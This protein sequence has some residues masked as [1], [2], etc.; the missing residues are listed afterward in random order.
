MFIYS[1]YWVN[2]YSW[3]FKNY[4]TALIWRGECIIHINYKFFSCC[5]SP[6]INPTPKYSS[7]SWPD[8][9]IFWVLSLFTTW[10]QTEQQ[11]EKINNRITISIYFP[12]ALKNMNGWKSLNSIWIYFNFTW[13][14]TTL[15]YT[16]S[17]I[18]IISCC[19]LH[20]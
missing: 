2:T 17:I 19:I 14:M 3:T 20:D 8:P 7:K 16:Q 9:I 4:D 1:V 5:I 6:K 12:S 11:Q 10:G 15:W 18:L 13:R